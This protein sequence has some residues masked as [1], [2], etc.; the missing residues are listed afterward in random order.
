M[1]PVKGGLLVNVPEEAKNVFNNANPNASFASWAIRFTASLDNVFMVL[2]GMSNMD[3]MLDNMSYMND[4]QPLNSEEK[5]V[6]EKVTDIIKSK[7]AVNCTACRYCVDDCPQ[8]I[9]IPTY[10]QLYN[11]TLSFGDSYFPTAKGDYEYYTNMNGKASACIECGK[12]ES[13]CPQHLSIM[14]G[15]K[16]V[17][18]KFE[19]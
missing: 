13:L 9:A 19:S 17:A 18:S 15:L 12:C 11:E 14:D 2:S 3:Q 7:N 5:E 10:F 8:H 16:A 6:I 1:E 4:F